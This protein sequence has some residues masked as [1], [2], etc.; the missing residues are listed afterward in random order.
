MK[1]PTRRNACKALCAY[2]TFSDWPGEMDI[3]ER[4]R[5]GICIKI[6]TVILLEYVRDR[7]FDD[8]SEVP[9]TTFRL[10]IINGTVTYDVTWTDD[11]NFEPNVSEADKL[12]ELFILIQQ[13]IHS[14]TDYSKP[15]SFV[16]KNCP[17]DS[18][19]RP[20][21]RHAVETL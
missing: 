5:L 7:L 20:A 13:I 19:Q 15:K 14:R 2:F 16:H 18:R 12:I 21:V 8:P 10:K 9:I 1:K 17:Q 6:K 11:Y 4:K 3:I